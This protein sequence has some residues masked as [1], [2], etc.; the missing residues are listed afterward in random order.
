MGRNFSWQ[1]LHV[2]SSLELSPRRESFSIGNSRVGTC[3]ESEFV[4]AFGSEM[5]KITRDIG[6]RHKSLIF[7]RFRP[8][9]FNSTEI[10]LE[11]PD[12]SADSLVSESN[13]DVVHLRDMLDEV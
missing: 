6:K 2:R 10:M 5:Y 9:R 12:F 1:F 3:S 11:R 4:D 8:A 7:I 13:Y